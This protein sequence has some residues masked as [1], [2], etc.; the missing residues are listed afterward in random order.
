MSFKVGRGSFWL[1]ATS[2]RAVLCQNLGLIQLLSGTS[3]RLSCDLTESKFWLERLLVNRAGLE[4]A[5]CTLEECHSDPLSYRFGK[6]KAILGQGNRDW[7]AV[8]MRVSGFTKGDHLVSAAH[9]SLPRDSRLEF[10]RASERRRMVCNNPA[11]SALSGFGSSEQGVRQEI[12][13]RR[14]FFVKKITLTLRLAAR[15]R[16]ACRGDRPAYTPT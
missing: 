12:A 9:S 4:P 16:V 5:T 8:L 6:R 7:L 15:G 3:Q 11:A 10:A 14:S 1:L 13:L 2:P